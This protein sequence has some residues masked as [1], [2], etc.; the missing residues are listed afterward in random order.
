M[1]HSLTW[2]TLKNYFTTQKYISLF[3]KNCLG[4]TDLYL[5]KLT[6]RFITDFE[7]YLRTYKP[8]DYHKPLA[9]KWCNET[10]RAL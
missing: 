5:S 1:K 9:N 2:G 4:T 8:L 3:L 10:H 7:Y 6:Y